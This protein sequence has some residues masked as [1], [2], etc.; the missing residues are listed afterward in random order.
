MK[1]QNAQMNFFSEMS[2]HQISAREFF[3][4]DL[5]DSLKRNFG[6]Q[7]VLISYFDIDG[8]FLS[9]IYNG[10]KQLA[11]VNH[12]YVKFMEK[13]SVRKII[14]L[15]ALRDHLTYFNVL[16][17]VYKSSDYI[18]ASGYDQNAYVQFIEKHFQAHYSVKL[19]FGIN[20][21]IQMAF[22]KSKEAGDFS[23]EEIE[24]I[25]Q[26]YVFVANSYKNFKKHEQRLIVSNIQSEIIELGEKAYIVTDDFMN[27]MSCNKVAQTYL[28]E[29]LGQKIAQ[30][31]GDMIPCNWLPFLLGDQEVEVVNGVKQKV[32]KDYVFSIHT[33]DQ[34]YSNGIID[35][36]HWITITPKSEQKQ[37]E[38]VEAHT[39]LT[40]TEL[41]VAQLMHKG[42]TYKAIA[43]EL[44]VS[45]HTIKKHVQ[46]IYLKCNV[47]SRYELSIFLESKK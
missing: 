40:A 46:N 41:K 21:Y 19:A 14:Y 27:L 8:Q 4:D 2:E 13:D 42:L 25:H 34:C 12:P 38:N 47:N 7:D 10:K 20:A 33:H 45:Y 5:L 29:I 32:I 11:N 30:M 15:E 18:E 39:L 26:I 1:K 3:S 17:R 9:W 23:A 6:F 36:Y 44:V 35:R 37:V 24:T 16:P 28:E 43:Q 31:N 22:F